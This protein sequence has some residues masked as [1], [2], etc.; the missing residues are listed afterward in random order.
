MKAKTQI[1][2]AISKTLY[3]HKYCSEGIRQHGKG[4]GMY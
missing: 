4:K 2:V 1:L 3:K